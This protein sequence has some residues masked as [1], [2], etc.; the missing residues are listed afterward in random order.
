MELNKLLPAL[1]KAFL[2]RI[3]IQQKDIFHSIGLFGNDGRRT[4]LQ[5]HSSQQ[6]GLY[7]VDGERT[8]RLYLSSEN[9]IE[10]EDVSL[11]VHPIGTIN[12]FKGLGEKDFIRDGEDFVLPFEKALLYDIPYRLS[13]LLDIPDNLKEKDF[14]FRM[15][16][17]EEK[18]PLVDIR[19][20]QEE[21]EI[22]LL[23]RLESFGKENILPMIAPYPERKDPLFEKILLRLRSFRYLRKEHVLDM[24]TG[25]ERTHTLSFSN[26]KSLPNGWKCLYRDERV[27]ISA[28]IEEEERK[29]D[30]KRALDSLFRLSPVFFEKKEEGKETHYLFRADC[31]SLSADTIIEGERGDILSLMI[32]VDKEEIAIL[33]HL[34]KEG[35]GKRHILLFDNLPEEKEG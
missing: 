7:F 16:A 29:V 25:K 6:D 13:A 5:L 26:P 33:F 15:T 20:L 3:Y 18:T 9:K 24:E 35:E 22:H 28:P 14:S 21:K 11:S 34:R 19:L 12:L 23:L 30:W 27:T 17:D 2:A 31:L 8:F 1:S 32:L 10:K 4:F